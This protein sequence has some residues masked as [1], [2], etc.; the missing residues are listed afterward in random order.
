M[1]TISDVNFVYDYKPGE[2][3]LVEL[4]NGRFVDVVNGV[5][6]TENVKLLLRSGK[7]E[8][9]PG[10]A[11][12][13]SGIKPDFVIDLKGKTVMPGLI[14]THC[15]TTLTMPSLLPDIWDIKLFKAHAEKQIEKNMAEC[16]IHGITIF[17]GLQ[18]S[19]T[20]GPLISG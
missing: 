2:D 10:L 12:Q 5:Y 1:T 3:A 19:G 20:P 11:G 4:A 8:A 6:F 14:N 16:L 9:M 18:L 15:H 13:P 17:T 7:I